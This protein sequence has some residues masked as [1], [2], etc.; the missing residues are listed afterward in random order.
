MVDI[1]DILSWKIIMWVLIVLVAGFIGQFGKSFAKYL[2]VRLRRHREP[3]P[4]RDDASAGG[5]EKSVA[6]AG[7]AGAAVSSGPGKKEAK[8]LLKVQKK[9]LKQKDKK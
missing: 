7:P 2:M 5:E 9:A 1:H 6:S 4:G 3:Q 8:A